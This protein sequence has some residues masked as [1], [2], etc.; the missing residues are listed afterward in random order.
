MSPGADVGIYYR[1]HVRQVTGAKHVTGL[2]DGGKQEAG[3][4]NMA[5]EGGL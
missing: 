2:T 4:L 1:S 5:T 3:V